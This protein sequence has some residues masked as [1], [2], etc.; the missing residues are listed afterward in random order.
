MKTTRQRTQIIDLN[1]GGAIGGS[2]VANDTMLC[3]ITVHTALAGTLTINGFAKRSDGSAQAYVIPVGFVGTI[4]F[5]GA[6]NSAGQLTMVLS[7]ATDNNRVLV[8]T[9]PVAG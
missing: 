5:G 2:L 7:S 3:G 9:D 8:R 1:A 6:L 4:D